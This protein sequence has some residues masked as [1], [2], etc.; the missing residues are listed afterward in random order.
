MQS[1]SSN[2]YDL[3]GGIHLRGDKETRADTEIPEI[4]QHEVKVKCAH[5][6]PTT[7][8]IRQTLMPV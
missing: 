6:V 2:L 8:G 3:A 1:A 5:S 7:Q 4:P